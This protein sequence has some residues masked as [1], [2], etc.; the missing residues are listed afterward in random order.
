MAA[1]KNALAMLAD[2]YIMNMVAK[3]MPISAANPWRHNNATGLVGFEPR[4]NPT[5]KIAANGAKITTHF[6]IP[7]KRNVITAKFEATSI[8][9][10]I[11]V[12]TA[13]AMLLYTLSILLLISV[14][15]L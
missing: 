9:T 8:L 14:G 13:R 11:L 12:I 7:V 1:P 3:L 4:T 2:V 15:V 6:I 5:A 10:N